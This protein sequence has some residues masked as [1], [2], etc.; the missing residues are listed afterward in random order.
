M[1]QGDGSGTNRDIKVCPNVLEL[2]RERV[3]GRAKQRRRNAVFATLSDKVLVGD[4]N[5]KERRVK[6]EKKYLF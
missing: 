6:D 5:P 1:G 4:D 3:W 2:K